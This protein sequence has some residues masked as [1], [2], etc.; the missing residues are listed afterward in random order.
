MVMLLVTAVTQLLAGAQEAAVVEVTTT[1]VTNSHNQVLAGVVYFQVQV[2]LGVTLAVATRVLT[3]VRQGM[4][5]LT[6]LV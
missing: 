4:R 3:A 1:V 5:D 6:P 2:V